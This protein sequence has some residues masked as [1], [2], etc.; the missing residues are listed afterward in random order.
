MNTALALVNN[1]LSMWEDHSKLE[2]IKKLF[3]PQ[4]TEAEFEFFIGLGKATGLN[5]FTK[6]IWA[7]KYGN[8]A[9]QVFIGRDGYRIAAQRHPEYDYH[10]SD[11]VY[12]NDEFKVIQG[13]VGHSYNLKNR[14]KLIGAYCIVKRKRSQ[15]PMYVFVELSEYT[16][17]KSLWNKETGKPATMIKKVA[18]AQALRMA[19]Q[20]LLGGTYCKEE[21]ERR[22]NH[23][24]GQ[25]SIAQR[26][27]SQT[28]KLKQVLNVDEATGEIIEMPAIKVHNTGR[29]DILINDEQLDEL[30]SLL[31]EKAFSPERLQ[32]ALDYYKVEEL[33]QLSDAQ[34]RLFILQLSKA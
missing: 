3:A 28:E 34:A 18:E 20:D 24:V 15:K 17:N 1:N 13:E 19:F 7:V 33:E 22:E 4:L 30:T 32:K 21:M 11:A 16:T 5:P 26:N 12:E 10:Q 27:L 23:E 8:G 2:Q 9:A 14:G 6:E 29:D 25:I 31:K